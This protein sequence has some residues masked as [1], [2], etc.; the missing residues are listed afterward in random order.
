MTQLHNISHL[1]WEGLDKL[2][3]IFKSILPI[4]VCLSIVFPEL[5]FLQWPVNWMVA[6]WHL[7]VVVVVSSVVKE[8]ETTP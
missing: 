5:I 7:V 4:L 1:F 2:H 3:G 8:A 6:V